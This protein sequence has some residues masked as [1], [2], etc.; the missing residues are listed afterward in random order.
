MVQM[1][2]AMKPTPATHE[3]TWGLTYWETSAPAATPMAEVHTS[4]AADPANTV[5][6]GLCTSEAYNRVASCVLSPSSATK[7]VPKTVANSWRSMR[8]LSHEI[9]GTSKLG[10]A[11]R[12]M[13]AQIHGEEPVATD[14]S[15]YGRP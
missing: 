14:G 4:A 13:P 7:T 12:S 6:F 1:P 8:R 15:R 3:R 11:A 2:I 5:S 10:R 9:A